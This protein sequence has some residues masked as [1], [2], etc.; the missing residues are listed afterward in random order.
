MKH[1]SQTHDELNQ[2][3]S[4][5]GNILLGMALGLVIGLGIALAAAYFI[6]K[7]PPAEKSNVR[8]PEIPLISKVSPDGSVTSEAQDPNMP[9]Q[10]KQKPSDSQ[11]VSSNLPSSVDTQGSS[12]PALSQEPETKSKVT[13]YIQVGSFSD[14]TGAE[15]NKAQLAMQ[16]MQAKISES[17]KDDQPIWRVRLGPYTSLQDMEDDKNSLENAGMAYSVIK[18]NK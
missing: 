13:Y 15:S 14:R 17:K 4:E 10:G 16:G 12:S 8:A 18:V 11:G 6:E 2:L 5:D 1:H 9:M 7:N 3:K